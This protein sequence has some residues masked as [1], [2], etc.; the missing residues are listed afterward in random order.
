LPGTSFV[1]PN[2]PLRRALT[3]HA[4]QRAVELDTPLGEMLNERSLVNGIVGLLATGGSTNHTLHLV[5]IAKAAGIELTWDDFN[6]LSAVVPTLAHVYPNGKAD[7]NH[8]AA[9]GG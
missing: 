2:T 1:P 6:D 4:G 5:A 7:I 3:E 9:A 8:F